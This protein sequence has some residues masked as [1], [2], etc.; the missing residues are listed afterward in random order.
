MSSYNRL[1]VSILIL[2][3]PL[4][5]LFG[6]TTNDNSEAQN[7]FLTLMA[8]DYENN[9]EF[10]QSGLIYEQIFEQTNDMAYLK[11]SIRNY[12][13][14]RQFEEV[15]KITSKYLDTVSVHQE[16]FMQE[17]ILSAVVL[18]RF[19]DALKVS[20]SLV[21][22]YKNEKN[23]TIVGDLYYVIGSYTHSKNYYEKAYNLNKNPLTLIVLT[24]LLF[25]KFDKQQEAIEYLEEYRDKNGCDINVCTKLISY[26]N[27]INEIENVIVILEKTYK[28]YKS[29][30]SKT[31][32]ATI[33]NF[34]VQAY[35]SVDMYK[36]IDFLEKTES[37]FAKLL[38]LYG[39]TKQYNKALKYVENKYKKTNDATLLGQIAI[40]EYEI[41]HDKKKIINGVFEKFEKALLVKE[42]AN[43]EN[44]YGYLL[45]EFDIDLKKGLK[46]VQKAH[47]K[48]P[49]NLAY[50]DSVAWGLYKTKQ[51]EDALFYMQK[52][53]DQ[54]GLE[55]EEIKYHYEQIKEC[56]DI[57]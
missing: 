41:A 14:A 35:E 48:Q 28:K 25:T 50:L 27:Q 19:E 40:L 57:R 53:I 23:F 38:S 46:L 44:Y 31:K 2:F 15:M 36:A 51:C 33:E 37:D 24:D 29:Q 1:I 32:L 34:M 45:I 6:A 11:K 9:K 47:T 21:K 30:F 18:E 55:N 56:N 39:I 4:Y 12:F 20:K 26:Y 52:V 16:Y 42:N 13:E 17:Y 54:V 5:L 8:L 43:Y 7:D 22:K 49:K 10:A 3:L